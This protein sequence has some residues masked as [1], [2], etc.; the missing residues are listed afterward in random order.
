[1]ASLKDR[2]KKI[3]ELRKDE[4]SL[5]ASRSASQ[6]ESQN[7]AHN[8]SD[9]PVFSMPGWIECGLQVLKR[10]CGAQAS[11]N[12]KRVLPKSLAVLVPDLAG[13]DLPPPED[14]LFFDLETTGLSGGAG[15]I[16]FLAAF[17][18]FVKSGKCYKLRVTQYLLLDYPGENDFMEAV[19]KEFTDNSVIVSYNGKCFDS[20]ILKTRCLMNGIKPPEYLHV[21]LLHPA[22]RL[23]KNIICDCSQASVETQILGIDRSGDIPGALAPEIWFEFLRTANT[24]RLAGICDHNLADICGLASILAAMIDIAAD[25]FASEHK[26][27]I[28]RLAL[29]WRGFCRRNDNKDLAA[30]GDELLLA[31]AARNYSGLPRTKA[32]VFR[33]LAIDAEKKS[34]DAL[35]ALQFAGKGLELLPPDTSLYREFVSRIT[36]LEKRLDNARLKKK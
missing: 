13:R 19:L 34:N 6:N 24:D 11:F 5:P 10:E 17:G 27:D 7:T 26:Y 30:I 20:Q 36:R 9:A 18:K 3:K 16:A 31:A 29:Y 2:L 33:A 4:I 1:M 23:W 12:L 28:G 32:I 35:A 25:P 22:R 15:T 14:F 8:G 21:D